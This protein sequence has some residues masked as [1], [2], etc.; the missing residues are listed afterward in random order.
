MTAESDDPLKNADVGEMQTVR[1]SVELHTI[2]FQP[3][4]FRGSDRFVDTEVAD[5]EIVEDEYGD[6]TLVVTFEG[7][8][9]KRLPR[10]WDYCREPRTVTEEKQARRSRWIQKAIPIVSA[11]VASGVALA[12][13]SRLMENFAGTTIDGEPIQAPGPEFYVGFILLVVFLMWA[14]QYLPGKVS[15]GRVP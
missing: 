8:V 15:G 7:E 11:L 6:E 3:D 4:V 5:V 1:E 13:F 2:N 10:N 12:V 9:T 14:I